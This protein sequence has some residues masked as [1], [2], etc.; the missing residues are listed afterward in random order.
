MHYVYLLR[1]HKDLNRT[2][3]GF[4]KNLRKRIDGHNQ[5]KTRSIKRLIPF[6]LIYYE[7]YLSKTAARKREIELKRKRKARKILMERLQNS[8]L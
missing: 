6:K 5:G 4:T 1:S 3:I 8:I 2:Y 7:A